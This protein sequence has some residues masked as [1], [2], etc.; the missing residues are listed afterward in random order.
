MTISTHDLI[1]FCRGLF[2]TSNLIGT[3][4]ADDCWTSGKRFRTRQTG[5]RVSFAVSNQF[6]G[7]TAAATQDA[8]DRLLS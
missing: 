5:V 2:T 1:E 4:I 3:D 7:K 8:L 6:I